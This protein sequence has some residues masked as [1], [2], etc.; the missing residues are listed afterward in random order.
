MD[1]FIPQRTSTYI[2]QHDTQYGMMTVRETLEFSCRCQGIGTRYEMLTELVRREKAAGIKPDV[3][4]DIFMKAISM[5]GRQ[6]N[7]V[8]DYVLKVLGLDSCSNTIV[9]DQIN[10]GISGGQRKRVTT[11]EMLVGPAKALFMDEISTGLDSATTFQIVKYLRQTVHVMDATILVSLLQPAPETYELFDDVILLAEG[12]IVYQGP[13]EHVLDFFQWMGFKCPE[14][15]ST[16]DFLQ[17]VT[18]KTDQQQYWED[19]S[20]PFRYISVEE[21]AKGFKT[22]RVGQSVQ[23]ELAI[24]FDRNRSHPAALVTERYGLKKNQVFKACLA[25]EVLLWKRNSFMHIFKTCQLAVM[26]FL[27]MTVFFRTKLHQDTVNDGVLYMGALFFGLTV[28]MFNG[29]AE[30]V[31]VVNRLPV[32]YKQRDQLFYP[33]WAYTIPAILLRIPLSILECI[34]WTCM[35]YYVIGF[36]ADAGRFF[37][38]MLLM[39]VISQAAVSL[40]WF[41]G[42]V[43]RTLIIANTFGNIALVLVLIMGGFVISKDAIR[44]WWIWAYWLSPL[45]YGLQALFS[46][47]FH[48]SRWQKPY[49]GGLDANTL[50]DAVLISRGFSTDKKWYWMSIAVLFAFALVFN[51]LFTM[52]MSY[53]NPID[54]PQAIL[55][56]DSNR[57]GPERA[58]QSISQHD[59]TPHSENGQNDKISDIHL[60]STDNSSSKTVNFDDIENGSNARRGIVL[61]FRA[62]SIAFNKINYYIDMPPAMKQQGIADDRLQ[63]L[64]DVSGAFRPGVLTALVGVSGAGKSTLMDVLAGRKTGGYIEGDITIS[65]FPKSQDTFARIAGYCEQNDIH[66]PNVTVSESLEYS[67]WL[68]L[69]TELNCEKKKMFVDEVMKLVELFPIANALVG[70]P[71]INGLT[72]EQRKRLTIAIELVANPSIIFMDEPTSGLDARAAAVVMTT[73][74]NTVDTG[75][76]VVCTIHQ[77][78]IFE[79]FDEL[80]LMK[81]GGRVIYAGPL[82][83]RSVDLIKYFEAIPGVHQITDGY[84]PASWMLDISSPSAEAH[85][86]VDFADIYKT[87]ALYQQNQALIK[88]LSTPIPG[89]QDL[90]FPSKYPTTFIEQCLTCL[91]KQHKSYWRNP[92]YNSVRFLFTIA[93]GIIFGTIFWR[94]GQKTGRTSDLYNIFGAVYASARLMGFNN[95]NAVQPVVSI[96]RTVFYREKGSY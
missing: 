83:T 16:S 57:R 49:I 20:Q 63:L 27:C 30:M 12:Q 42:S 56:D 13:R 62:L 86:Q 26:S 67:A 43:G 87:S 41:L 64:H 45:T 38:H 68:R 59:G 14:R 18:S 46:N 35:T 54:K 28:I 90:H 60:A 39:F 73:V 21:F 92:H 96:E 25:R 24:P 31:M 53:L 72:T 52:A 88:E 40:F 44:G 7:I 69:P 82:G 15:K 85:L 51:I 19:S 76:T 37:R 74:R 50:G 95:A 55:Q 47:E 3:D 29:M 33:A 65:G 71:G 79:S 10:R 32:F 17:E 23:Q 22:F 91:W 61:P 66:S 78:S 6:G 9:G 5:E 94:L 1:E 8:T 48:A 2:S 84:N 58:S 80:L 75:R 36:A 93:V 34:I 81:R 11:G 70:L 77:P 89:A 4:I